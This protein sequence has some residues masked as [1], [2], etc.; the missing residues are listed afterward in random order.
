MDNIFC[1]LKESM[2][3]KAGEIFLDEYKKATPRINFNGG[4]Y[5]EIVQMNLVGY[6]KFCRERELLKGK[7]QKEGSFVKTVALSKLIQESYLTVIAFATMFL[8]C[9]IWDYAATNTSQLLTEK[10][11]GKMSLLGKWQVIPKLVNNNKNINIDSDGIGLLKK[12]V[13]ERND[14][15][16]SKSK[17][18]PE[19]YEQL[20][21]AIKTNT[22][23]KITIPETID[24]IKKCIASL[25]EI[26]TTNYWF[27]AG[28]LATKT[29]LSMKVYVS[30]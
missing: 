21:R 8:E 9:I 10:A 16:H 6:N 4:T 24:C 2:P 11:L 7:I 17:P 30:D 3:K 22:E 29:I 5:L 1:R 28:D 18:V 15:V 25:K 27:F 20:I 19:S 23:S 14:I 12:L 13:D 26:D